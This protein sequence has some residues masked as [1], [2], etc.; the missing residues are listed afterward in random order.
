MN[1]QKRPPRRFPYP[2]RYTA[3][4]AIEVLDAALAQRAEP[5]RDDEHKEPPTDR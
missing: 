2:F 5:R 4:H 1:Q 3:S